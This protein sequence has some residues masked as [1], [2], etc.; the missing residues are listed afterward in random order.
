MHRN[1][2]RPISRIVFPRRP[3]RFLVY[4]ASPAAQL[5]GPRELLNDNLRAGV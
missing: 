2:R 1:R 5:R 4:A 3:G